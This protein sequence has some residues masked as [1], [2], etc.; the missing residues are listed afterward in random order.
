MQKEFL[1]VDIVC[2]YL[3]LVKLSIIESHWGSCIASPTLSHIALISLQKATQSCVV[4]CSLPKVDEV[5]QAG[6][7]FNDSFFNLRS[8]FVLGHKENNQM[9]LHG[10]VVRVDGS[11]YLRSVLNTMVVDL[12]K[13]VFEVG[14]DLKTKFNFFLGPRQS[15]S[16]RID[17]HD[18]WTSWRSIWIILLPCSRSTRLYRVLQEHQDHRRSCPD[19][20]A[21]LK[22]I[23]PTCSFKLILFFLLN[24]LDRNCKQLIE[25]HV[26]ITKFLV[27]N[28]HHLVCETIGSHLIWHCTSQAILISSVLSVHFHRT[29]VGNQ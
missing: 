18:S 19:L 13:K 22:N 26:E 16:G 23:L 3:N 11:I 15:S 21:I 14:P 20:F 29:W 28:L 27:V 4:L 5:F 6:K 7:E 1:D 9:F 2:G 25:A 12:K 24:F 8:D 10:H 17:A